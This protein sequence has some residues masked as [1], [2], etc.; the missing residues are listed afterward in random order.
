MADTAYTSEAGT[1]GP[2]TSP[3]AD[4]SEKRERVK[5]EF[6]HRYKTAKKHWSDWREE[7]KDLYELI[8]GRQWTE[9][10]IAKMKE[11]ERPY[12]TF[13]LSGKYMDA[14]T[15]LQINNRQD[16]RYFPREL[17]DAKP[18]ELLTG[19]V[20]W[21]RDQCQMIDEETDAFYD[22]VLTGMGCMEGY[23]DRDLD[24]GGVAAGRRVDP[25]EMLPDPAARQRNLSDAR[26]IIRERLMDH[27]EYQE[28]FGDYADDYSDDAVITEDLS[29]STDEDTGL[30]VIPSP[31]DYGDS[32]G[33]TG[34]RQTK[35]KCPVQNYQYWTREKRVLVAAPGMEERELT[36]EE[37]AEQKSNIDQLIAQGMQLKV[38]VT[39]KRCYYS[40]YFSKGKMGPFGKSPYQKG[41]TYQ[42]ITGKRDRN[43]MCWYG[44]GRAM[45]DSQRWT[46]KF[47]SSI[48]YTLM[49][50]A[51]GGIMAE[52]N[53]FKDA[54]K[55]EDEWANPN[56]ITWLKSG[57]LSGDKP[58][59]MPKPA[60]AYPTGLDRLMEFAMQSFPETTG[61]NAEILGLVDREQA[62]VV[63]QQRKQSAMAVISWAFDAMRR[64]YRSMGTMMAT[65]VIEYMPEG[66]I[67]KIE[68][69]GAAQ[70]VPLIKSQLSVDFDVI[71][72]EAPTSTNMK[73]RVWAVIEAL[74]P[75]LLKA[76]YAPPKEVLMYSPLPADLQQAW[77]KSLEPTPEQTAAKQAE[78]QQKQAE[79][80]ATVAKAKKDDADAR[81]TLAE[82]N[83]PEA[84]ATSDA[85][86]KAQA[87]IKIAE[88]EAAVEARL[89]ELKANRKAETELL[90]AQLKLQNEVQIAK[91]QGMIDLKIG[92]M[93]AEASVRAAKAK[94]KPKANGSKPN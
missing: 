54:R 43:K 88:M 74:V 86:V 38:N 6:L 23:L 89:E 58:R 24:P 33:S 29:N 72:D 42:M 46:N 92:A 3:N 45:V 77:M 44:L 81:A 61:I 17:G 49:T 66:M 34:E 76:G 2:P 30:Q 12:V 90:I 37:Y 85:M 93:Q 19:A 83:A 15:G 78:L 71:A 26:Y 57:A 84:N 52:E 13:N 60:A 67:V 35:G 14:V 65:Y 21:C 53:A 79:V 55:A 11:Q 47:F 18:N 73:E 91:L 40:A 20:S 1:G 82:I 75:P 68:G 48:L 70:F 9:E 8:A 10:D 27:D 5:K 28:L 87:D 36:M 94:P 63:E 41:F 80:Q 50:N 69:Q 4:D 16:I 56:S 62:G 31:H 22:A 7:A 64:Y 59:I 32:T 25:L 51:K 39:M